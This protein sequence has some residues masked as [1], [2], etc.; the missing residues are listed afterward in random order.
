VKSI[1]LPVILV[2]ATL[3]ALAAPLYQVTTSQTLAETMT[4][5]TVSTNF[6]ATT[7][8]ITITSYRTQTIY[9]QP[10]AVFT[11]N[12]TVT[13]NGSCG[14]SCWMSPSFS[15]QSGASLQV[16]APDCQYCLVGIEDTNGSINAVILM[17]P[18]PHIGIGTYTAT[19]TVTDTGSYVVILGNLGDDPIDISGLSVAQ[20]VNSLQISSKTL[21]LIKAETLLT[22][23]I[24][25][26]QYST[27]NSTVYARSL[28]S[29]SSA[30]GWAPSAAV[31][32]TVAIVSMFAFRRRP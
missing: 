10:Q 6:Q 31:V 2:A 18:P 15:L 28:S 26:T 17:L 12:T 29:P 24:N 9:G 7:D 8:T 23:T 11:L 3:L 25:S 27:S 16:T 19:A 1:V 22:T 30:L 21:R 13:L 5:V 14:V 32:L 20:L 4:Q